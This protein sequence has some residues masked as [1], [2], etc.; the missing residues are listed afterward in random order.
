MTLLRTDNKLRLGGPVFAE[1]KEP[2][3][4]VNYH[5]QN[6]LSAAYDPR[7][8]DPVHLEEI[9]AAYKEADIVIAETGAFGINMLAPNEETRRANFDLLCRRLERAEMVG[10]LC[11]VGHAGAPNIAAPMWVFVPDPENFSQ[12]TVDR[13]VKTI[14]RLI[15]TVK[16]ETTKFVLE[17]ESRILPDNPDVYLEIIE[18]VDRPEFAVHLDPM[19]ITSDPR[20]YYFNGDFIRECFSKLGPYTVSSH[21][22]DVLLVRHHQQTRFDETFVG[23]GGIDF[24]A[25][26]S[27]MVKL[28]NDVP[29]MIEHVNKRQLMWSRDHI[30]E[31]AA[32]IGVPIRHAEH[33]KR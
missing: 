5:L 16:P 12:A 24:K 32:E 10:A 2:Q 29:M 19:N 13:C 23:N 14:Q 11:C 20:R 8:E 33:R 25:Y 15:D 18:A 30:Y 3:F 6:G 26:I 22:K 21:A 27:G 1:S 28:K 7:V 17:T 9:K 4:L 31:Q